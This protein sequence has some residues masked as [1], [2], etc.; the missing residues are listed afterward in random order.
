[1]IIR[2][3]W[4]WIAF[5][6]AVPILLFLSLL[7]LP[8]GFLKG[9]AED[10]LGAR[11][12]AKAS[13]AAIERLDSFSLTPRIRISGI[14]IAQPAWAGT[15][16]FARIEQAIV[17]VPLLPILVGK[18]RP[19]AID[20]TGLDLNLVRAADGQANWERRNKKA[21]N[22]GP[23][24]DH[25]TIANSRLHLRDDKRHM[26]LDAALT[27]DVTHGLSVTGPG[28]HRGKPMQFSA[29][30]GAIDGPMSNARWPIRLSI[31]SPLLN[32]QAHGATDRPLDL[33]GFDA[34]ISASG[35]DIVYLDDVIEA[36]LPGTQDFALK[37]TVRRD[38]PDWTI[39]AI[40]GRIGRSE[41]TGKLLVK[42]R[43]G[44]TILDGTLDASALDFADLSSDEGQ[45]IAAAKRRAIGP[46]IIPDTAIHFEKLGKVDG[47]LRVSAQRLLME[48][49]SIVQGFRGTMTMDHRILTLAPLTIQL[50]H[51]ALTGSV[52]V[53]HRS[54]QPKLSLDLRQQGT[55]LSDLLG[56]GE[57]IEGPIQARFKLAGTGREVRTALARADGHIAIVMQGG[58]MR[59]KLAIFASGDVLDSIGAAIGGSNVARIP[60]TCL[61]S[62]FN[63]RA[64]VLAPAKLL[65]DTPVGRSDGSG[66]A[67]L[68]T[69]QLALLFAGRSK[70][71]DPVQLA[72]KIRVGGTF[73]DPS[74]AL[75]T[76]EGAAPKSN[77]LLGKIGALLG[78]LRTKDD[79]GRG[80]P[81]PTVN[82]PALSAQALK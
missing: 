3:W 6:A 60:V 9:A 33:S 7:A 58:S 68:A 13:I 71:P 36:G 56:S 53:D 1:M 37:A 12:E 29:V 10:R 45:A 66:S 81:V 40:S 80:L 42:K 15:G 47:T 32:L 23:G 73:S 24:I 48:Q 20:V 30:G 5:V 46:R 59:K 43:D 14:R 8:I 34:Q 25:L 51:G 28:T 38:R 70:D 52:R 27:V 18:F 50:T 35:P 67:S 65:L 21:N 74:L 62:S 16:D 44:R 64:G 61:V 22:N 11:F 19:E 2:R 55:R 63:V 69:E 79:S 4:K 54:G 26:T 41:F 17:R 72:A 82:C 57:D 78:S 76:A 39:K 31:R 49:D 75:A 77:G